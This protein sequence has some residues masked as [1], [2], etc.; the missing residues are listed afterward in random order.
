MLGTKPELLTVRVAA[1]SCRAI[2]GGNVDEKYRTAVAAA[3]ALSADAEAA[4]PATDA[5]VADAPA[6]VAAA[7]LKTAAA[8]D[9][10][11]A[12]A[13]A[14]AAV[15]SPEAPAGP[16]GPVIPVDPAGPVGPVVCI[17]SWFICACTLLVIPPKY[18]PI[19]VVSNVDAVRSPVIFTL[20]MPDNDW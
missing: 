7:A 6:L 13:A 5:E 16:M 2:N 19:V 1:Q 12:V 10:P 20:L 17:V 3:A 14:V 8:A 18:D 9:T 11:A 15:A 4:I